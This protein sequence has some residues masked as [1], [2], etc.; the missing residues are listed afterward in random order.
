MKR[1]AADAGLEAGL[2]RT[3]PQLMLMMLALV[4]SERASS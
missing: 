4:S 1:P 3:G 2:R